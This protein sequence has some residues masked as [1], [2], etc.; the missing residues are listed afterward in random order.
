LLALADDA[1]T[2]NNNSI[3][4]KQQEKAFR[5][6]K[7]RDNLEINKQKTFVMYIGPKSKQNID[8]GYSITENYKYLGININAKDSKSNSK[9]GFSCMQET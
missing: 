4:V 1:V 2:V 6:W 5:V 9:K 7:E 3:Q 8:V